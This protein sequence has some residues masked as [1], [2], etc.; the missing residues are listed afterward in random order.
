MTK[1]TPEALAEQFIALG[2]D[3]FNRFWMTVA[4]EWNIE[5][6]ELE[7]QWFFNGKSAKPTVLTVIS[8]MHSAVA[9]GNRKAG[10]GK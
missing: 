8:A 1:T 4:F 7:M 5:D 6:S 2:P 9:S 3:E 10:L